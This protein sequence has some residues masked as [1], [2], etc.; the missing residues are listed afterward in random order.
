ML[1][2]TID[3]IPIGMSFFCLELMSRFELPTNVACGDK[4]RN[5]GQPRMSAR[6]RLKSIHWID[7]CLR[8]RRLAHS[9]ARSRRVAAHAASSRFLPHCASASLYPPQV[10]LG[11]AHIT[12]IGFS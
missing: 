12:K 4:Q 10:A 8:E 5:S 9:S 2:Y 1:F 6:S 3:G 11:S 7:F